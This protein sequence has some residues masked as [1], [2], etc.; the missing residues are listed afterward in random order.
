MAVTVTQAKLTDT[1]AE[2]PF[3]HAD[4]KAVEAVF[5]GEGH[6]FPLLWASTIAV[7]FA[8]SGLAE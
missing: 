1:L 8:T 7:P 6:L 5:N 3:C 4:G 2:D